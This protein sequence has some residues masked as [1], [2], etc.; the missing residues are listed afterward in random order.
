M[1]YLTIPSPVSWSWS[2]VYVLIGGRALLCLARAWFVLR[3]PRGERHLES[4]LVLLADEAFDHAIC[5]ED[6]LPLD[7][8]FVFC[9]LRAANKPLALNL[10]SRAT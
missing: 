5:L 3:E 10:G 4:M 8:L 2:S 6:A 7:F 9:Y 1:L